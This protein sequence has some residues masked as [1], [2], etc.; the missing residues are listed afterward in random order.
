MAKMTY[1]NIMDLWFKSKKDRRIAI[2]KRDLTGSRLEKELATIEYKPYV[3]VSQIDVD[4]VNPKKGVV[5]LDFNEQFVTMLQTTGYSGKSDDDIVNAWFNDFI[6]QEESAAVGQEIADASKEKADADADKLV[7]Y[8]ETGQISIIQGC[9][10]FFGYDSEEL[11]EK[12]KFPEWRY[13]DSN[14]K[15]TYNIDKYGFRN[16]FD[17]DSVK[18]YCVAVGCSITFG[19]GQFEN[20]RY[21]S[22]LEKKLGMPIYNMGIGG[23][24]DMVSMHNLLWFLSKFKK[25][26]YIIFQHTAMDRIAMPHPL[27]PKSVLL[28]GPWAQ[29]HP[30]LTDLAPFWD[31]S[32][33]YHIPKLRINMIKD[34]LK[35]VCGDIPLVTFDGIALHFTDTIDYG[36][37]MLHCGHL[38]AKYMS[39]KI[40]EMIRR[41][42]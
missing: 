22:Y 26:K 13:S 7:Y 19:S 33:R 31:L 39:Y 25:P 9:H 15:L 23:S 24:N 11:F 20:E 5:K 27:D 1:K 8:Q 42:N 21:T 4:P 6:L 34:Q 18:E 36:R 17:I 12:N 38:H 37:D 28:C 29:G 40:F 14:G 2:A 41:I 3:N 30:Y 32:D 10:D 16:N 35:F